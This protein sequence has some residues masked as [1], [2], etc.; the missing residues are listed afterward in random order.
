MTASVPLAMVRPRSWLYRWPV[1]W[2]QIP[3]QIQLKSNTKPKPKP[4]PKSNTLLAGEPVEPNGLSGTLTIALTDK[5]G[6][7]N[8]YQGTLEYVGEHYARFKGAGEYF[9]L[10]SAAAAGM[11]T[12][13]VTTTYI[14]HA[15]LAAF[16]S[17]ISSRD[18]YNLKCCR[19]SLNALPV[20]MAKSTVSID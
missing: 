8:R 17:H 16:A 3:T 6:R 2:Q 14:N 9:I 5:I 10:E 11:R 20:P 1:V 7:D 12:G 19:R 18:R 4:K 15:T 13:L